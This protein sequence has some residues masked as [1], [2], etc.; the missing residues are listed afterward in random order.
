MATDEATPEP[1]LDELL[2]QERRLVFSSL[3][4]NGA[5]AIGL[6]ILQ[7]ATERDLPVTIEVR[8]RD[9]VVFRAARNGTNATNDQYIGGKARLVE[10][11]G[12]ASLYERLR[13]E[14]KG[15]TFEAATSLTFP[16][17]APH[18]G[19]FPLIVEGA[20]PV[21]VVV[22]SGLPQLEDHALVVECLMKAAGAQA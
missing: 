22:V 17:Y 4:E 16:E 11:F 21:G 2:D 10:R 3:D 5:V 15:T 1:T 8:L 18:G 6:S 19:G 20:G 14:A 7:A 13:Y 9:R 12:H